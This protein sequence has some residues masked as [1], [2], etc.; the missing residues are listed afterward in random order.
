VV[1]GLNRVIAGRGRSWYGIIARRESLER[2]RIAP[3]LRESVF[4]SGKYAGVSHLTRG[5]SHT[6]QSTLSQSIARSQTI[7]WWWRRLVDA[8]KPNAQ[9]SALLFG[10]PDFFHS[11]GAQAYVIAHRSEGRT[12]VWLLHNYSIA[13][14]ATTGSGQPSLLLHRPAPC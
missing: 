5:R 14:T 4:Y 8:D 13:R 10:C 6:I 12:A 11:Q 1:G 2:N 7:L 3:R 9:N